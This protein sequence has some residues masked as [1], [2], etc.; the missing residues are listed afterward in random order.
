MVRSSRHTIDGMCVCVR[1][2]APENYKIVSTRRMNGRTGE[3]VGGGRTRSARKV[4]FVKGTGFGEHVAV[5][6]L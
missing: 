5:R 4:M 3:L 2:L 6:F 1:P